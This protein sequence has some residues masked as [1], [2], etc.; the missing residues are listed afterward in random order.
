[1]SDLWD[2]VIDRFVVSSAEFERRLWLV[3]PEHWGLP[4]PC[5]AWNVRQL[6]NHMARGN[7]NYVR[8]VA[9]GTRAEFSQLRDVDAL[10]DDPVGGY[11]RS[12]RLCVA[13]F[14]QPGALDRVVDYPLGAI[15][16]AQA[17]AVRTTDATIHTWDLAQ[18]LG[19]DDM[20]D[21]DLIAWITAGLAEIYAGLAETPVAT[22]TTHRFFGAPEGTLTPDASEQDRLL[23][24]MG[25]MPHRQH[26]FWNTPRRNG[27]ILG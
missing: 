12:V 8:L 15:T 26:Q 10:G 13:A 20:L 6:V 16:G 24:R 7:L 5:A 17:L 1:M 9:G 4:T 22:D 18:A 14:R 27:G 3:E 19:V 11:V 21:P 23:H 2:G 25:R